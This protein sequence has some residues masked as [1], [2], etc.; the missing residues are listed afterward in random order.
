[1]IK[2][3]KL[4]V[5]MML[6]VLTAAIT[7]GTI[8]LRVAGAEEESFHN[9][10]VTPGKVHWHSDMEIACRASRKSGKPVLLFQMMGR[11]DD[12]FC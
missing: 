11:L 10:K 2:K 7:L 8:P 5:C 6:L 3:T 4:S 9:P 12:Q 1:M